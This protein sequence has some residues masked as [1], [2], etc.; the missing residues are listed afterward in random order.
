MRAFHH[1]GFQ[2]HQERKSP[3]LQKHV[4]DE[5]ERRTEISQQTRSSRVRNHQKR[6]FSVPLL[7][8]DSQINKKV[9]NNNKIQT[10]WVV[11]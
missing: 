9:I 2:D 1:G 4:L 6:L 10:L 11:E 8:I 5:L 3:L 7:T